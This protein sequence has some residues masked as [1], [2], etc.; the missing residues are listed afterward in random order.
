[1]VNHLHNEARSWGSEF[2]SYREAHKELIK[3]R[4]RL[5]SKET[6]HIAHGLLWL[7]L[8]LE[9]ALLAHPILPRV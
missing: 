4:D 2:P 8:G 7:I 6:R 9:K 1:M 3:I 5:A